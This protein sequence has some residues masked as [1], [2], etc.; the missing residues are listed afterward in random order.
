MKRKLPFLF[1]ESKLPAGWMVKY[2]EGDFEDADRSDELKHI[3]L[4]NEAEQITI[5][6]NYGA[7]RH[8]SYDMAD[9]HV[10]FVDGKKE[11]TY[12]RLG[13]DDSFYVSY[14]KKDYTS[15]DLNAIILEQVERVHT[16][17]ERDKNE[18]GRVSVPGTNIEVTKARQAE[19]SATLQSGKYVQ[20][21][22]SGFGT[23][24]SFTRGQRYQY[25]KRASAA[26][27]AFFGITDG[28]LFV[29]TLD[30]D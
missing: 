11:Y 19:L 25:S 2:G 7:G 21:T 6:V 24:Y 15:N 22:P 13:V 18:G 12:D 29:D 30:C 3:L 17:R 23:G 26:Q 16:S 1:D 20:I 5:G 4:T 8:K 10:T 9:G 14:K 28:R 27:M